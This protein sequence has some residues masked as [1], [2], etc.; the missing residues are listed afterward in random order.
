[1]E[2]ATRTLLAAL[3]AREE[4]ERG[5]QHRPLAFC[6]S[7]NQ[8]PSPARRKQVGALRSFCLNYAGLDERPSESLPPLPSPSF[9]GA[10][11]IGAYLTLRRLRCDQTRPPRHLPRGTDT[12]RDPRRQGLL[13]A[14]RPLSL[15]QGRDEAGAS[16]HGRGPG[17]PPGRP[18]HFALCAAHTARAPARRALYGGGAW[19]LPPQAWG[20]AVST[21]V[22]ASTDSR[23]A[24]PG[25][26][27]SS[28]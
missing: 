3:R 14:A 13:C 24:K 28:R 11:E 12:S 25:R 16:G 20:A 17:L 18:A 9:R 1:M 2:T 4:L 19:H 7:G 8:T 6:P 23:F 5:P 26:P 21:A 15:V 10:E 27:P 22:R